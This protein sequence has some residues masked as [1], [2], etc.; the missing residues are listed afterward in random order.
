MKK[1]ITSKQALSGF[2][3][4]NEK[5][6]LTKLDRFIQDGSERLHLVIDFDRT[7]TIGKSE[8]DDDITTWQ[9]LKRH[10]PNTAQNRY[11]ELFDKYRPL[12]IDRKL[13]YSDA[14][15]WWENT[16]KLYI[17]HRIN[18]KKVEKNFISKVSIRPGAKG[19]FCLCKKASVP[20]II[21][22][23]GIKDVINLWTKTFQIKPTLVLSTKLEVNSNG[24]IVDWEKDSLIHVLN[25]KEMGHAELSRIR[26]KRPNII[27]IGDTMEDADM[28]EG[29]E[30]VL[31]IRICEPRDDER[32]NRIT[33]NRQ[34][35]DKYDLMIENN[36]LAPI[37]GVINLM[38]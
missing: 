27:L 19:L 21:L 33:F 17:K 7:L 1:P 4:Q 8:R 34:T 3:L 18:L 35:F 12:E 14:V 38:A 23:A 5:E 30:N 36:T 9:I 13:T 37:I 32:V 22:S 2:T 10:L 20:T 24:D 6:V 29:V 15:S 11:C 31:R 28:V 16:L 26:E 25:K